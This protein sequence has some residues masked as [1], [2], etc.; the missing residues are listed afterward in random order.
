[1]DKDKLLTLLKSGIWEDALIAF[2]FMKTWTFEDVQR[3]FELK[4]INKL[5]LGDSTHIQK[6]IKLNDDLYVIPGGSW[7]IRFHTSPNINIG[8]KIDFIEI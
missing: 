3:N 6:Y 8:K 5:D 4:E 7:T 1:M 2:T